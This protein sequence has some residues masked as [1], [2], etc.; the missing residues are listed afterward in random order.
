MPPL[1]SW[2][3]S[4]GDL[5][6]TQ[7]TFKFLVDKKAFLS[8]WYSWVWLGSY[9]RMVQPGLNQ[10]LLG[11]IAYITNPGLSMKLIIILSWIL[12][13]VSMHF[14]TY[15]LFKSYVAAFI[16]A[17]TYIFNPYMLRIAFVDSRFIGFIFLHKV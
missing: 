5:I 15:R 8:E 10:V 9:I 7:V 13:G 12:A 16:S 14:V 17:L 1:D 6:W 3:L 11:L 2:V 4:R